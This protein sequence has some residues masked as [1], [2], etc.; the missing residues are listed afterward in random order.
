MIINNN[1]VK[2]AHLMKVALE[3]NNAT[4]VDFA[5]MD[6]V[7]F[8]LGVA[9]SFAKREQYEESLMTAAEKVRAGSG[10]EI[11]CPYGKNV[12]FPCCLSQ[13]GSIPENHEKNH[14]HSSRFFCSQHCFKS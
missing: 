3:Q 10:R 6:Y 14:I 12:D 11:G 1:K 4:G 13:I 8:C 7:Q 2:R 9:P 5:G